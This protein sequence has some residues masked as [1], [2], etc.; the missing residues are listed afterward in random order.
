MPWKPASETSPEGSF[1][2]AGRSFPGTASRV[3]TAIRR[4]S[5]GVSALRTVTIAGVELHHVGGASKSPGAGHVRGKIATGRAVMNS[6]YRSS[7]A[8]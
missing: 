5:G 3:L 6:Q 1:V 4:V 8:G 2:R 7:G